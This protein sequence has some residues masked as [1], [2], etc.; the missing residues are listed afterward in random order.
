MGIRYTP[1]SPPHAAID[2]MAQDEVV[3]ADVAHLLSEGSPA[4]VLDAVADALGQVV[5]HDALTLHTADASIGLLRPALVRDA[6]SGK[7]LASGPLRYGEGVVG[8]A[9]QSAEPRLVTHPRR[10]PSAENGSGDGAGPYSLIVNPLM[11]RGELKGVLCL[12]RFGENNVFTEDELKTAVRFSVL[13][14][15]AIDNA[16]IRSTLESLAMTDHLTGLHNHRYFQERLLEEMSRANRRQTPV[17]LLIYDIDDFKNVNDSYGHLLGDQVLRGVASAAEGICRTEDPVCRIGGE[18][19]AI[20]LPGQSGAQAEVLAERIRR[21][22]LERLFPME[23]QV[24]VSIGLAEAPANA[25][26]PRDLFACADLALR[27]AKSQ[28]KNRVCAYAGRTLEPRGGSSG[29]YPLSGQWEILAGGAETS[30]RRRSGDERPDRA[31]DVGR[32]PESRAI[33]QMKVLHRVSA[34]LNRVHDAALIAEMIAIEL[35]SLIDYRSCRVYLLAED[36]ETLVPAASRGSPPL[37]EE[38]SEDR[39]AG[40]GNTLATPLRFDRHVVGVIVMS[41]LGD[42]EFDEDDMRLIEVVASIAANA[43]QNRSVATSA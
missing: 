36:G 40:P 2:P 24:T 28:G 27:G 16:D 20:I 37:H 19:F 35:K 3:I 33:A 42:D 41:K 5:P 15:L 11:A 9:A 10:S 43:L 38:V 1:G 25:S 12:Y 6:R 32:S 4:A 26:S 8:S 22:V 29:D 30:E 13:A 18:E 39:T 23:T 14:A 21:S 31:A 7:I 17:S 34:N